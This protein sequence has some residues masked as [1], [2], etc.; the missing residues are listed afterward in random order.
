[1]T[2]ISKRPGL[3]QSSQAEVVIAAYLLDARR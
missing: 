1:M 3:S 2:T